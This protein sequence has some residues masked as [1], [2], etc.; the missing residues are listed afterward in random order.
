MKFTGLTGLD[1][2]KNNKYRTVISTI[3]TYILL[4]IKLGGFKNK[5]GPKGFISNLYK[6]HK[7]II[8]TNSYI[9]H[10]ELL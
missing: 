8:L 9:S 2:K 3:A 5:N 6:Y 10:K 4:E 7:K 1:M